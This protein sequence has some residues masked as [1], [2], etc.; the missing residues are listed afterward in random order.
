MVIRPVLDQRTTYGFGHGSGALI[1][2]WGICRLYSSRYGP[3]PMCN[4]LGSARTISSDA[5]RSVRDIKSLC[6]R[7]AKYLWNCEV[8]RFP[9]VPIDVLNIWIDLFPPWQTSV[10]Q[11]GAKIILNHSI[12]ET[13]KAYNR[14]MTHAETLK[15]WAIK[16]TS[17]FCT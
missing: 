5:L 13:N 15:L 1:R 6:S 8:D 17:Y 12:S 11:N 3:A 4:P 9:P 16:Y 10:H 14:N 7:V 2:S